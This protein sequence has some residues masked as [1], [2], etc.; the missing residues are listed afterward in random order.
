MQ[1]IEEGFVLNVVGEC[2]G[3]LEGFIYIGDCWIESIVGDLGTIDGEG[4]Y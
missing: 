3:L 2:Y 4:I 1:K